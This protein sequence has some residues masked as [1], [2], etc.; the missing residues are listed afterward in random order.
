MEPSIRLNL[1]FLPTCQCQNCWRFGHRA[2]YYRST[3]RCPLCFSPGHTRINS[4]STIHIC[5]NCT[6]EHN[7]FFRGCTV[8]KFESEV[9][10]LRFKHGLTLEEARQEPHLCGFQQVPLSQR[11]SINTGSQPRC[12]GF[13]SQAGEDRMGLSS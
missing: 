9:A 7:I 4:P 1:T 12:S 2:K 5:A 13:E 8:Y 3:A 11:I 10:A 6:Q